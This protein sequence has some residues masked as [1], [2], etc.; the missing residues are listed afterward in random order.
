MTP[1]YFK[2]GTPTNPKSKDTAEVPRWLEDRIS[3]VNAQNDEKVLGNVDTSLLK[4][5]FLLDFYLR[6]GNN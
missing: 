2:L 3:R 6:L 5:L 1:L 4:G